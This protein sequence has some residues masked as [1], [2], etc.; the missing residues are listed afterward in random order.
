M[1]W[2]SIRKNS[3]HNVNVILGAN[4]PINAP[5][6]QIGMTSLHFAGGSATAEVI[7]ALLQYG[8]NVNIRDTVI[9]N[10]D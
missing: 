6:N 2:D 4:F 1:L 3:L 7:E 8:P 5:L 9:I 10:S